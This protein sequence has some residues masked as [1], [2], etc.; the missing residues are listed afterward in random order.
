MCEHCKKIKKD[1]ELIILG[2]KHIVRKKFGYVI[3]CNKCLNNL[4]KE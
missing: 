3:V 4:Q 2:K 1:Y